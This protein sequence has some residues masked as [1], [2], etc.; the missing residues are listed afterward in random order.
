[1][2][3]DELYA[4]RKVLMRKKYG[5]GLTPDEELRLEEVNTRL[6]AE[7]SKQLCFGPLEQ[8]VAAAERMGARC[9]DEVFA[10]I[11][12]IRASETKPTRNSAHEP[13]PRR[14]RR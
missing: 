13:R 6:E 9:V 14:R 5:D 11:R 3:L 2:T 1:M 10:L 4:E 12:E 8:R 7:E